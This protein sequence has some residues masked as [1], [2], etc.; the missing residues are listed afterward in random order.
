VPWAVALFFD[1]PGGIV[2]DGELETAPEEPEA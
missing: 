2:R 1:H